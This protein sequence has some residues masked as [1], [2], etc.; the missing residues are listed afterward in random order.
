MGHLVGDDGCSL[1]Q[2]L[3]QVLCVEIGET[4]AVDTVVLLQTHQ[5]VHRVQ[6]VLVV[7]VPPIEGR[8]LCR[9]SSDRGTSSRGMTS[10]QRGTIPVELWQVDAVG[11][12]PPETGRDGLVRLPAGHCFRAGY[13]LG[14]ELACVQAVR[15]HGE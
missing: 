13:P 11:L 5:M 12:H 9:W 10:C 6:V 4:D 2:Q 8:R 15:G 3:G 14:K 7:V 1:L